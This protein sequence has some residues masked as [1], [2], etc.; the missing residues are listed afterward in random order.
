MLLE[1]L[2]IKMTKT[3]TSPNYYTCGSTMITTTAS[4]AGTTTVSNG[5]YYGIVGSATIMPGYGNMQ[6]GG[7]IPPST[8]G[9]AGANW[10]IG[11]YYPP[12]PDD[13]KKIQKQEKR[14]KDWEELFKK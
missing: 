1:R 2:L 12:S 9:F 14:F 13:A 6:S 3:Q 7:F 4:T 5:P 10:G 11:G 8:G